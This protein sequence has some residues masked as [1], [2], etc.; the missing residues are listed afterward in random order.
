MI[1]K[2]SRPFTFSLRLFC[3]PV[4]TLLTAADTTGAASFQG[5]G[6]LTGGVVYSWAGGLSADGSVVV[7]FSYSGIAD[8]YP[9]A[10]RWTQAGGMV[11]LGDLPG[12]TEAYLSVAHGVS[13][14][15]QVVVGESYANGNE[16]MRWTQ[17]GGMVGLGDLDGGILDNFFESRSHAA[18]ADGSVVVGRGSS[19]NGEAFRWTQVG[20]LVGLGDLPNGSFGSQAFGVSADGSIVVG[21]G[22]SASGQEAF[23]WTQ[24]G[25]MVGLGDL[26]DGAFKSFASDISTNAQVIVG[27]GTSASGQ[28]ASRWTQA[29]GML[30]LSDLPG[31]LFHSSAAATN[32]D[33]SVI[34]GY[35]TT[36]GTDTG[37][38]T[39]EAFIWDA[40]HG[41]RNLKQ[42]LVNVFHLDLTDW[43][44]RWAT[45][46][47]DD[48]LTIAGWGI[49]PAGNTEAWLATIPS[50][51]IPGDYNQNG[52]VDAADYVV[53][54]NTLGSTT[55][56]AADGNGNNQIDIGDYNVWRTHFGQTSGSGSHVAAVP[57]PAPWLL[58]AIGLLSV[59]AVCRGRRKGQAF[60]RFLR[61]PLC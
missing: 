23:R 28:E 57:E 61:T 22:N 52:V 25:G 14:D 29:G 33:G 46:V 19:P 35:S 37:L 58:A 54:R 45:G 38:S 31:G 48:G 16:A 56:L 17:A 47:S 44:L 7:G 12:T 4:A 60:R 11:G 8:P 9:E 30:G 59:A 51:G 13:A 27:Y 10:F 55:N 43:V 39:R 53:Y 1:M 34:V 32:Q 20:G 50:L 36:S 24:A 3:I 18:S 26:S 21:H 40:A 42:V 41:M 15:G 6:D 49:N 5:L 2:S